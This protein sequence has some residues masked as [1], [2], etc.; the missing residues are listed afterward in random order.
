MTYLQCKD[1]L[2]CWRIVNALIY[3]SK[4]LSGEGKQ[5]VYEYNNKRIIQE[6][7]PH[8]FFLH[9]RLADN[10]ERSSV[11]LALWFG[12]ACVLQSSVLYKTQR[13]T[14]GSSDIDR[15]YFFT[16]GCRLLISEP[17]RIVVEFVTLVFSLHVFM[18]D[19]Y[20]IKNCITMPLFLG[21]LSMNMNLQAPC[22]W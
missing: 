20:S 22:R 15:P 4:L 6:R 17:F 3:K 13:Q 10:Y 21:L 2:N 18:S 5:W 9:N 12:R 1:G 19:F 8:F 11:C 14:W 16:A 7:Y